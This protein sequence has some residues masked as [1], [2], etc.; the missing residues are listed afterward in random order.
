MASLAIIL[1]GVSGSGKST[2]GERLAEQLGCSIY[3]GD[4]FHPPQNIA[5]MANGIPLTDDDRAPWLARL[6]ELIQEK[7]DSD[8]TLVLACSALKHIYRDQLRVDPRVRFVY[9]KGDFDLIWQRM[10]ARQDH[11]MQAGMLQSQFDA[12]EPPGPEEALV[13]DIAQDVETIV[14]QIIQAEALDPPKQ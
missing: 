5:K 1:M 10:S 11:Y 4:A 9:L 3:D 2:V 14:A 6:A 8:Q 13:I 12:L 7:L